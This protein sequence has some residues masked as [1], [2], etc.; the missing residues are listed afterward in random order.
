[1]RCDTPKSINNIPPNRDQNAHSSEMKLSISVFR[2]LSLSAG[3]G[4]HGIERR[5]GVY[6]AMVW[7]ATELAF[8]WPPNTKTL[9]YWILFC[10]SIGWTN[11]LCVCVCWLE[12]CKQYSMARCDNNDRLTAMEYR[13]CGVADSR[14]VTASGRLGIASVS[15][16]N[17]YER[18]LI[19]RF[20]DFE[21]VRCLGARAHHS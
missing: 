10:I 2:R 6:G 8:V 4:E 20:G 13:V 18:E 12:T 3:G 16:D 11:G 21:C 5:Y 17:W 7:R 1:M 19:A 14:P 15:C 9:P